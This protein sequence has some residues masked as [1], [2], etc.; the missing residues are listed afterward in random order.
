MRV[1]VIELQTESDSLSA[2]RA[3]GRLVGEPN[4]RGWAAVLP[5]EPRTVPE[6][7]PV[8]FSR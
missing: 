7:I 8:A 5:L 6:G 3:A 1:R 4:L 2:G